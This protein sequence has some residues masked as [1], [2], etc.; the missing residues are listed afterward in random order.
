MMVTRVR[1]CDERTAVGRPR[2]AE[3]FLDAAETICDLAD[4]EAEVGGR[5]VELH[6]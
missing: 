1:Q 5:H 2:K 4:D 6:R 3:Q